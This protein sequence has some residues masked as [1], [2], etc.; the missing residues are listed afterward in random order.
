MTKTIYPFGGELRW[1]YITQSFTAG[2]QI[3]EVGTRS[4]VMN[5][6]GTVH[7][8]NFAHSSPGSLKMHADT[9]VVDASGIGRRVWQF[10]TAADFKQG[11]ETRYDED[12]YSGGTW[13]TLARR[14]NTWAQQG[15][16]QQRYVSEVL[17]TMDVSLAS[18]KQT[19]T[20][21]TID[22]YGN[23]TASS[24]YGFASLS[25][26]LRTTACGYLHTGNAN[27]INRYLLGFSTG[28]TTTEGGVSLSSASVGYDSFG[29]GMVAMPGGTF[30]WINPETNYRALVTSAND[31]FRTVTTSYNLAG[32]GVSSFDGV[33]YTEATTYG[34]VGGSMVPTAMTPNGNANLGSTISWDNM[35]RTTGAANGAGASSGVGYQ[36]DGRVS[37]MTSPYGAYTQVVYA[38]SVRQKRI[39][40][41]TKRVQ[42]YS[43][44]L[45]RPAKEE[46]MELNNT[47]HWT[48]ETEYEPCACSPMGKVKR[49]SLPYAPSG[50]KYW[51][52]YTY[53]GLGRTVSI[54]QPNGAG[55][56]TYLY[57]GNQV[58]VTSPSGKWKK[59]EMNALG[60]L[61]KVIEPRPAGGTYETNYTYNVAGKLLTV[62]M[63]R[64]GVT[65][66]R[67]FSYDTNVRSR[68]R[69][70]SAANP[71]NGTVNY[72]YNNDATLQTKTDAK[73]IKTE[74]SYDSYKRP[75]QMRKLL[76]NGSQHVEDRC[77]RVEYTY[78][79]GGG[80]NY[81]KLTKMRWSWDASNQPCALP[82]SNGTAGFEENYTYT[83]A[84]LVLSKTLSV[85]RNGATNTWNLASGYTYNNEGT[86]LTMTYP[87]HRETYWDPNV[88]NNVTADRSMVTTNSFGTLGRLASFSAHTIGG[89]TTPYTIASGAQYNHFSA[90]TSLNIWGSTETRTYNVLGQLTRITGLGIDLEYTFSASQN[91]G[92]ITS[93]KNWV[94]GEE[95]A[96]QYDSLERLISAVTTGPQWGLSFGYDGFGNRLT[97]TVTKGTAPSNSVLVDGTTNRINSAGF[98]YDNNGNMTNMPTNTA[99]LTYDASNRMTQYSGTNVQEA[100]AY[101]PDNKRIW[102]S[103]TMRGCE[104]PNTPGQSQPSPTQGDAIIFYSAHGLKLGV[105]CLH[106]NG[107]QI[108][109][110]QNLYFGGRF[111]ARVG[112]LRNVVSIATDRLQ[113]TQSQGG[114]FPYGEFKSG[115]ATAQ[116]KEEFATYTRDRSGLD[117]ADQRWYSPSIARFTTADPLDRREANA[118][119]PNLFAYVSSDP[120]NRVDPEGLADRLVNAINCSTQ[121]TYE[122]KN[123]VGVLTTHITCFTAIM[124]VEGQVQEAIIGPGHPLA[125]AVIEA[126]KSRAKQRLKDSHDAIDLQKLHEYKPIVEELYES[127]KSAM[128]LGLGAAAIVAKIP[129]LAGAAFGITV[130]LRINEAAQKADKAVKAVDAKYSPILRDI[131]ASAM[132]ALRDCE[133]VWLALVQ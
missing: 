96:Y 116:D 3:R 22:E 9:T 67:S 95:V 120:T 74:Y 36:S 82:G 55:T 29:A 90:L 57:E 5:S 100:Y 26:P 39:N 94:S 88:S 133:T 24:F 18:Q 126:C 118:I 7:N 33:N 93:Q 104:V 97:Q 31:G 50:T 42:Q 25:T 78:D 62:N 53:D 89:L 10:S 54:A 27:Y 102:R 98:V 99:T 114:H 21:Q 71:E 79:G 132:S 108:A 129:P 38:D 52:V 8:Y 44:G 14:E 30:M 4:L 77:Q 106:T 12:D 76:W 64:D 83:A 43:D 11:L 2:K 110:E 60:Q 13:K 125:E 73:N 111:V 85:S 112:L 40:S 49:V 61:V 84:G 119:S 121:Q 92:K 20:T 115:S 103:N 41:P 68:S 127:A 45:G 107:F 35:L 1:S 130:L 63:V 66:N 65:Q 48:V 75:T 105:Y 58:T 86:M 101:A 23:V 19:K 56:T 37:G 87:A 6:G 131:D 15:T 46:M 59:Y 32:Q 124:S 69:L 123:G 80:A 34:G 122:M 28:C 113:S 109:S 47:L 16:S 81:G 51:T 72:V 70:L 117:Y 128:K 17:S 91:D